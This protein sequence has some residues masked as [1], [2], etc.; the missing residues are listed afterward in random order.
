MEDDDL[1][2]WRALFIFM[3][4]RYVRQ[5]KGEDSG[6]PKMTLEQPASPCDFLPEVVSLW[7]TTEWRDLAKEFGFKELSFNQGEYGGIVSKPT[8]FGGDLPLQLSTPRPM[9]RYQRSGQHHDSKEL[10][11]WSPG[12]MSMVA[13]AIQEEIRGGHPRLRALSWSEHLRYNHTPYRRDCRVRQETLQKQRPHKRV[14]N[15]WAGVLSLDRHCWTF[16]S[17]P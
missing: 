3:V 12:T 1:L 8:T 2:L 14:E 16:P 15:P 13:R 5:A 9:G 6:L 17:W 4:S 10:A 7:E 11:R